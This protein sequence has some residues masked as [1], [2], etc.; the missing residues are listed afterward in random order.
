MVVGELY[1]WEVAPVYATHPEPT[2]FTIWMR[3]KNFNGWSD[4]VQACYDP[5]EEILSLAGMAY[6]DDSVYRF[7]CAT[8][9]DAEVIV[10]AFIKANHV[11]MKDKIYDKNVEKP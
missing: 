6:S 1:N 8:L 4:T 7:Y 10:H 3:P 5:K 2:V 9:W 11:D